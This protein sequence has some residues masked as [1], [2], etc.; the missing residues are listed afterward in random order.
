MW[1]NCTLSLSQEEKEYEAAY[2]IA[3][4]IFLWVTNFKNS[5]FIKIL[6]TAMENGEYE[7]DIFFQTTSKDLDPLWQKYIQFQMANPQL[8][9]KSSDG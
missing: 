3:G 4:G 2:R 7:P 5:N 8:I 1:F 9:P 6:N